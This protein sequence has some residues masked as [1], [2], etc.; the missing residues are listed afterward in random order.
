MGTL[1]GLREKLPTVINKILFLTLDEV[2]KVISEEFGLT[3]GQIKIKFDELRT[4]AKIVF[5]YGDTHIE[6]TVKPE[7][8]YLDEE[9]HE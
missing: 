9:E 7:E 5:P 4:E 2:C 6:L 1:K 3:E 8:F